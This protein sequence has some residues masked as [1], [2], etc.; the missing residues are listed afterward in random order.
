MRNLIFVF[1]AVKLHEKVTAK[2]EIA[3]KAFDQ[4]KKEETFWNDKLREKE[5][6]H[7]ELMKKK[8]K[9]LDVCEKKLNEARIFLNGTIEDELASTITVNEEKLKE[10]NRKLCVNEDDDSSLSGFSIDCTDSLMPIIEKVTTDIDFFKNPNDFPSL[11]LTMT[12][13]AK[14]KPEKAQ[15][16]QMQAGGS[17]ENKGAASSGKVSIEK[18]SKKLVRKCFQDTEA[19]S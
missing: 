3:V 16:F 4:L 13:P 8:Q 9:E 6:V 1:S 11:I 10:L 19:A 5:K 12:S 14:N 2:K 15:T 7:Q 17:S 18:T